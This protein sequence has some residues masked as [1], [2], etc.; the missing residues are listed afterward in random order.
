MASGVPCVATDVGDCAQVIA[1]ARCI[2]PVGDAA[3][4]ADAVSRVVSMSRQERMAC[5]NA[6][7]QRVHEYYGAERAVPRYVDAYRSV[8]A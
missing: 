2:A 6:A 3:R 8:E 5:G 4:L 7:K 1:D